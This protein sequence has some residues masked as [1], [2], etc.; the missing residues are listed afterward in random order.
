M[1][2]IAKNP[3]EDLAISG[4]PDDP[5]L[6]VK[7]VCKIFFDAWKRT[8]MELIMN[9]YRSLLDAYALL[10][11]LVEKSDLKMIRPQ[12]TGDKERNL[13]SIYEA[14]L[15]AHRLTVSKVS[16]I[17]VA[18][19][20][21]K[22]RLLLGKEFSYSFSDGDLQRIQKV[23]NELRK[24]ISGSDQLDEDYRRRLL[25]RLEKLQSELHKKVS[26]L[27]RFWGLIGEAGVILGK[28]GNDAKPIVDRIRELVQIIWGTQ[29]R[30]EELPSNL[31]PPLIEANKGGESSEE[32]CG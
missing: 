19:S 31:P 4:L 10:L 25:N 23:V 20:V 6:A 13:K 14:F 21:E 18:E 16:E 15:G 11:V 17:G 5:L 8:S 7:T 22:Y 3:F 32:K 26:D 24:L 28:L 30:G 9:D 1:V 12:L 29:A 27:D 2:E